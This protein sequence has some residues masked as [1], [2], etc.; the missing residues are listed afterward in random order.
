MKKYTLPLI[1][2]VTALALLSGCASYKAAPLNALSSDVFQSATSSQEISVTAK[3]FDRTDCKRYL[4]R[5]VISKGYQ[6]IQLYIQNNSKNSYSFA[7]SRTDLPSA[8]PEEVASKVHTSTAGRALGYGIPGLLFA[9]PLIIPAVVDGIKSSE[10]NEALDTDFAA[11]AARDQMIAPYSS[12]NKLIFVPLY[13]YQE[14]FTVTLIDKESN[15]P[16][17]FHV[18]AN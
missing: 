4:D 13:D 1:G 2:A 12:F 6:P 11:K 18:T 16:K 5:D 8:R 14:S 3:A 15:Q 17:T 7:L 9:L 10:A